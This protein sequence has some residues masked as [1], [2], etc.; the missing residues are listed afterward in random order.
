M[1]VD[2]TYANTSYRC[3]L[4]YG[5]QVKPYASQDINDRYT[6]GMQA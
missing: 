6:Q 4:K 3:R 5:H 1:E 2:G